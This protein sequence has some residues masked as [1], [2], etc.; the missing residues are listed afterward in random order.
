MLVKGGTGGISVESDARARLV[1]LECAKTH[2]ELAIILILGSHLQSSSR[3]G[4]G[5][6]LCKF[7]SGSPATL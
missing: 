3:S 1:K 2:G 7:T 6:V 4:V 5:P